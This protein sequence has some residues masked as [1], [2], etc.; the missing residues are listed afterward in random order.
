MSVFPAPA[1]KRCV[2]QHL[3]VQDRVLSPRLSDEIVTVCYNAVLNSAVL[4]SGT[5]PKAWRCSNSRE[6]A[7]QLPNSSLQ[8]PRWRRHKAG[9]RGP[10]TQLASSL[11]IHSPL[12]RPL[13]PLAAGTSSSSQAAINYS[14]RSAQWHA[15][16]LRIREAQQL[17]LPSS[18]SCSASSWAM[19]KDEVFMQKLN[20]SST[21]QFMIYFK[22]QM[23]EA[24][25]KL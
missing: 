15:L 7:K 14:R 24:F 3:H 10:R 11:L 2:Y 5:T 23:A 17:L 8:P 16:L 4:D 21:R 12:S 9:E 22:P 6:L 1:Q 20:A 18:L 13:R 25:L 19:V